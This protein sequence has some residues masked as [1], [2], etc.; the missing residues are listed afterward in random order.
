MVKEVGQRNVFI[1][2]EDSQRKLG[3]TP[4]PVVKT[5]GEVSGTNSNNK[6]C[7]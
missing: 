2:G 5:S 6:F 4:P 7:R 1:R 3:K